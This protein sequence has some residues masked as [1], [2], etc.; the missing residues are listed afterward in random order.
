MQVGRTQNTHADALSN[1]A[2]PIE[3]GMSRT[4][5]FGSVDKLS[6]NREELQQVGCAELGPSWMDPIIA[7]LKDDTLPED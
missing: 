3:S 2:S 5:K 7:Y 6:I 1:L 4:V